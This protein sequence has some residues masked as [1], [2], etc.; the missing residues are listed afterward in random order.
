MAPASASVT[1][2][3]PLPAAAP[4]PVAAA[5]APASA[6]PAGL[7]PIPSRSFAAPARRIQVTPNAL[8]MPTTGPA[9][10]PGHLASSQA[11]PAVNQNDPDWFANAVNNG[12]NKYAAAQKL[13][14]QSSTDTTSAATGADASA[15]TF[16]T[17]H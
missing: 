9:A 3:S 17:I 5:P 2:Q 15:Q 7:T 1:A 10:I 6:T 13:A 11:I 16:A 8:P 12:L 14:N 4:A